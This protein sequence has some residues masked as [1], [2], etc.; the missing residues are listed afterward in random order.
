MNKAKK[1]QKKELLAR[2]ELEKDNWFVVF[3]SIRWR[4]GCIDFAN[5]FDIVAYKN[6]ERKFI[7]CKHFNG[8]YLPHQEEIKQFKEA[9]GYPGE[10]YELWIWHKP[11]WRGRGINKKWSEAHWDKIVL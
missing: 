9:Y 7:S 4:F 1:G 3:K 10:S 11:I 6:K 8:Y 2:R 5:M